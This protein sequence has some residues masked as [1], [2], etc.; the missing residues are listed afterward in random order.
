MTAFS[1]SGALLKASERILQ[2][3]LDHVPGF[4]KHVAKAVQ[5]IG[6][7]NVAGVQPRYRLERSHIVPPSQTGTSRCRW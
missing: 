2:G 1:A 5:R 7:E 3:K 6:V 4:F